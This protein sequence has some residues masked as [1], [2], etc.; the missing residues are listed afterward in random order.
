MHPCPYCPH[1]AYAPR[2]LLAHIKLAH[3]GTTAKTMPAQ[4][5][6]L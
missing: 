4:R 1:R 3:P 2:T 6:L 5:R